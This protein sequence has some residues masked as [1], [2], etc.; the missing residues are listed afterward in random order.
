MDFAIGRMVEIKP[1][2]SMDTGSQSDWDE[3]AGCCG[4]ITAVKPGGYI[5]VQI[6]NGDEVEVYCTRIKLR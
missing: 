5:T 2:Y 3:V 1:A 6:K 4:W